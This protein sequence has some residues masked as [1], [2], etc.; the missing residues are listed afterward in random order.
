MLQILRVNVAGHGYAL[1]SVDAGRVEFLGGEAPPAAE[2][3]EAIANRLDELLE[4]N[5]GSSMSFRRSARGRLI[6]GY[7]CH[8]AAS[9]EYGRRGLTFLHTVI[10]DDPALL[11]SC[12]LTALESLSGPGIDDLTR[13]V[14]KLAR[15]VQKPAELLP[16]LARSFE[17]GRRFDPS[18]L[19]PAVPPVGSIVHDCGGAA[20]LAWSTLA[21]QQAH[22]N[23]PWEVFDTGSASGRTLTRVEPSR[24]REVRASE[25]LMAKARQPAPPQVSARKPEAP[26][27]DPPPTLVSF[28]LAHGGARGSSGRSSQGT[29]LAIQEE[30]P[31]TAADA[32][33]RPS[34]K[35]VPTSFSAVHQRL[36][37]AAGLLILI[38]LLWGMRLSTR[39]TVLEQQVKDSVRE[40]EE[41][42]ARLVQ[43]EVE[44]RIEE[45]E[46]S[47]SREAPTRKKRQSVHSP[48]MQDRGGGP[49]AGQVPLSATV[50]SSRAARRAGR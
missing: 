46:L 17:E 24:G 3:Y 22:A 50:G 9:D 45:L 47:P 12:A 7:A 37:L 27:P 4:R 11:P 35:P 32:E 42:V 8:L 26:R 28:P 14:E 30:D 2:G 21:M 10:F 40:Q 5:G 15:G 38:S 36:L 48:A 29:A 6:F 25:L 23:P 20:A 31:A 19:K 13:V 39:L 34:P 41:H 44:R 18:E 33:K 16:A 49:G 1:Y 43:K